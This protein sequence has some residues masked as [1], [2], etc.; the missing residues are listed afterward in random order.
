MHLDLSLNNLTGT[1]P[2]AAFYGCT[3]FQ[4]LDLSNNAFIG[5]LPDDINRLSPLLT[6]LNLLMLSARTPTN[7]M[8][9]RSRN[10][11]LVQP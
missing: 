10:W 2:G 7:A 8:L 1:F 11:S 3:E 4:F 6:V 5:V 9:E